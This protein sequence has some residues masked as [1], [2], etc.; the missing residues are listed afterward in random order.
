MANIQTQQNE[1]LDP[2]IVNLAKAI[3]QTESG[4]NYNAVG[5]KGTSQGAYQFQPQSWKEWAGQYL[6]DE[7]AQMTP[8]NQDKVA[9]YKIKDW[10]SQGYNPDQIASLW[11]SGNPDY[12]GNVGVNKQGLKF[13][14]P[15]YVE[16]VGKVYEQLRNG[17]T[18]TPEATS[19]TVGQQ[20]EGEQTKNN[21]GIGGMIGNVV[22]SITEPVTTLLERPFQLAKNIY[23]N[24]TAPSESDLTN[25]NQRNNYLIS[26]LQD[27][28]ASPYLK[29]QVE[30]EVEQTN[31]NVLQNSA[32]ANTT[33]GENKAPE[34]M[35]DVGKDVGR[36]LQTVAF[37]TGG[38]LGSMV[39]GGAAMGAGSALEEGGGLQQAALGGVL[40]AATGGLLKG[41]GN[42]IGNAA[43]WLPERIA[44]GFLPGINKET[45][46]YAVN[47]GLGSPTK[48]LQESTSSIESLGSKLDGILDS[49]SYRYTE[50]ATANDLLPKVI[51]DFP[52]A[53]LDS[54]TIINKLMSVA[55][56]QKSLIEKLFTS[57][58]G[59]TLKELHTLNADIGKN[60]YKKVFDDPTMKAGKDIANSFWHS[61]SNFITTKAPETAPLFDQLSKEYPL[62]GALNKLIRSGEKGKL[63][64][65]KDIIAL[66]GGFTG[67]PIGS[68][69]TLG[70]EKA[71]TNPTVN[72]STGG[73][74]KNISKL[75]ENKIL[76]G[77]ANLGSLLT[78][79]GVGGLAN[80]MIPPPSY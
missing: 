38:G 73:V 10:G 52:N 8:E 7:N 44:R 50:N 22:K 68:L 42:L 58:E 16:S 69:A 37:G 29:N 61:A 26:G 71:L 45:A 25:Q 11:N 21:Q 3:A 70:A 60:I 72:L 39:A 67:G 66:V 4:G 40:G 75:G 46:Q 6:G 43:E 13:D 20:Q 1:T 31:K 14:T 53:G 51:K 36:G 55:P 74:L 62:S 34:T 79:K 17:Q 2:S 15:K 76:Q 5:D 24:A 49:P 28:N 48:M 64:T 65:L 63:L 78:S 9:Y 80:Q 35:Q 47:K 18:P 27:P 59:L 54:N 57:D 32:N 30:Q 41:A 12:A 56:N 23:G 77:G 33:I 19:S